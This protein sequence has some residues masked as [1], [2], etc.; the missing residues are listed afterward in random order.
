MP[1]ESAS[2]SIV[3]STLRKMEGIFTWKINDNFAGGVPDIFIEGLKQDLWVEAKRIHPEPKRDTTVIHLAHENQK[4]LTKQQIEWLSRRYETRKDA[5]ILVYTDKSGWV[6]LTVPE[7][8]R[9]W[10]WGELKERLQDR[11]EIFNQIQRIV[12]EGANHGETI[13]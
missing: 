7:A 12:N 11:K 6:L 3:T 9:P 1:I 4:Y 8:L 5:M 2:S 10:S 13:H